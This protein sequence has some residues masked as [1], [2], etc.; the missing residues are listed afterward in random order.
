MIISMDK[1]AAN[2]GDKLK[3]PL[4][5]EVLARCKAWG[6]LA[7]AESHAGAGKYLAA[8]QHPDK[9]HISNLFNLLSDQKDK[10]D[11]EAAGGRYYRL[12]QDWWADKDGFATYPGSVLQ[13]ARFLTNQRVKAKF[14]VTEA[15]K[16]TY[17]R[18]A[19]AMN[20]YNVR[21]EYDKFQNK[22]DWLT[23]E[24][25]LVMLIDP[26]SLGEDF[27]TDRKKKLNKGGMDLPT[28]TKVLAPCWGKKA[29][30]VLLWSGFG[31][32]GGHVKR[33]MVYGWLKCLCEQKGS[34]FSCYHAKSYY[35]FVMGVGEGKEVT[36]RLLELNWSR[37]WLS[38]TVKA[39]L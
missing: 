30:V 9:P 2:E 5:L 32:T 12:L 8:D 22:L 33:G 34:S 17:D 16:G 10:P 1:K 24:D 20:E 21:P 39:G 3:H 11:E 38:K 23:G 15:H 35:T 7:Y 25:S 27:G 18:L 29:A 14:R 19:K 36:E 37:S 4:L 31:N 28:L 6:S 13:A 26:L